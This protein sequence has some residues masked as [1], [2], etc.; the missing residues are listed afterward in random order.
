MIKVNRREKAKFGA[1]QKSKKKAQ[2]ADGFG[3]IGGDGKRNKK[4]RVK[5]TQIINNIEVEKFLRKTREHMV[6]TS[7]PGVL[8][9][10][11]DS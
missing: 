3:C 1:R 4:T 10:L 9:P 11:R 5:E 2:A 6:F 7:E 8:G